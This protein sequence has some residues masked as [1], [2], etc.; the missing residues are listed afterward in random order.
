M[1]APRLS[2][3]VLPEAC[4][5]PSDSEGLEVSLG[6]GVGVGV[7]V[8]PQQYPAVLKHSHLAWSEEFFFLLIFF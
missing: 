6:V 4:P 8:W 5:H 7:W 3:G 1:A 2:F